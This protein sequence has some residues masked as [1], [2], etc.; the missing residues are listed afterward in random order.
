MTPDQKQLVKDTWAKVLPIKDAAADMFYGRLFEQYPEV[1]P[2][3]KGDMKNQGE[4]LMAMLNQAV[5]SLDKIESL[6]DPLKQAGLAHR[7]Y[8]VLAE[9]YDKV[10]ASFLWTLEQGLGEFYTPEVNDAW[11]V[12][13][14][15]LASVMIDG[16]Q[17]DT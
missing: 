1:R 11:T 6:I 3:F 2:Y 14:Q 8:G 12:T 16:A 17:Y 4:K 15:T 13:Y 9:D 5:M 10:G 7:G